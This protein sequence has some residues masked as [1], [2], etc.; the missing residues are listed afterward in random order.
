VT[1]DHDAAEGRAVIEGDRGLAL[2]Q[3]GTLFRAGTFAGM[4]DGQLL[5]HFLA[6]HGEAGELAFAVL[7]ERHG[8][9]VLRVCRGALRSRVDAEDAFQATF[10]ALVRGAGSIRNRDS[11]APWLHGAALR[12]SACARSAQ[13]RRKAHEGRYAS[14]RAESIR[15]GDRDDL[16]AVL[17]EEVGRLPAR[18]RAAVVL[19]DLQGLPLVEAAVQLGCPVGTIKSRVARG[20]ERLR[21]RLVRRGVAPAAGVGLGLVHE[22]TAAVGPALID[23]T[24]RAAIQLA[25]GRGMAG[26]LA[27]SVEYLVRSNSRSILMRRVWTLTASLATAGV[28]AAGVAGL[29]QQGAGGPGGAGS[30]R[31][32]N[33]PIREVFHQKTYNVGDL[34]GVA[35]EFVD[36]PRP[37]LDMS[38]LIDL[39]SSTIAPD[40]W[41][42]LDNNGT[43]LAPDGGPVDPAVADVLLM[44]RPGRIIPIQ[45]NVSLIIQHNDTVHAQVAERLAQLRRIAA[46]R[47]TNEATVVSR[48]GG[49]PRMGMMG[50]GAMMGRGMR[51]GGPGGSSAGG[52][53]ATAS[54][55][56]MSGPGGPGAGSGMAGMMGMMGRG[57]SGS[58]IAGGTP[59]GMPPGEPDAKAASG[60][61]PGMM[62]GMAG[63][64]GGGKPGSASAGGMASGMKGGASSSGGSGIMSGNKPGM[65]RPGGS[66]NAA[67]NPGSQPT[68]G[69]SLGGAPGMPPGMGGSGMSMLGGPGGIDPARAG[70]AA[71]MEREGETERR[72]RALEEKLDRVLKALDVPK[73]KTDYQKAGGLGP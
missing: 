47:Q 28:L 71:L 30:G 53:P 17:H 40:T 64:M 22:A 61:G 67:M 46:A 50:S 45:V 62:G 60:P 33:Q 48:G 14:R 16:G 36:G 8:P 65:G 9:M 10:L 58:A 12:V 37:M 27:A 69:Q 15:D 63:M 32:G 55:G 19:C 41:L 73:A 72:L 24:A 38:P 26:M 6:R 59:G 7:I 42:I 56:S 4:S 11:L 51:M 5:E 49:K 1:F 34:V 31:S 44:Q 25:A 18:Y 21:A 68:P 20:R 35:Q 66:G 54:S 2:R 43:T 70:G 39:I 29:A 23:A 3:I 52:P 57:T 13:E